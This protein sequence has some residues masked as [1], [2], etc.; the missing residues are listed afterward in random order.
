MAKGKF[1]TKLSAIDLTNGEFAR[2]SGIVEFLEFM[3][4][5]SAPI[6][7]DGTELETV[8]TRYVIHFRGEQMQRLCDEGKITAAT[9]AQLRRKYA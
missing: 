6:P 3:R 1:P 8:L 7:V 2:L 5:E 9:V 4:T